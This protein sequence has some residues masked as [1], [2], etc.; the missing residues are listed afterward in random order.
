MKSIRA[1]F[2][3]SILVLIMMSS[4]S[5][6]AKIITMVTDPMGSGTYA[7]TSGVA[8]VINKY[9]TVGLNV[10][11]QPS[12]G[13]I[14]IAGMLVTEEAEMGVHN[15]MD[16]QNS[17]L[18]RGPSYQVYDEVAKV[19]PVRLLFG[20]PPTWSTAMTHLQTGIKTGADLKG[21][22]FVGEY[23]GAPR[24]SKQ[25]LAFLA[26]WGLTKEDVIWMKVPGLA[27]G[28]ETLIEGTADAI[29]DA[30]PGPAA[31][32]ELDAK[33]GA[34]CLGINPEGVD[35]FKE[36]FPD[37]ELGFAYIEPH[38]LLTGVRGKILSLKFEDYFL[39]NMNKISDEE[40]Y[41][42][43]EVLWDNIEEVRSLH[44]FLSRLITPDLLLTT[45]NKV[46]YHPGAI[47]FYKEKGIWT[48]S[49]EERNNSLLALEAEE[50]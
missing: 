19:S 40:A 45:V 3:V 32:N 37:D 2:L 14:E 21:K 10:K 1:L 47:K 6:S 23:S 20:G 33:R 34:L 50:K 12:T 9:N 44:V 49:L 35:A 22:K 46:P 25:A 4:I 27:D 48:Q 18:T 36:Y 5:S 31:I 43:L 38:A 13:G 26:S 42:I 8:S 17:W 15:G 39:A 7:A 30:G 11:V 16:A 41:N 29:G 28:Y 24:S